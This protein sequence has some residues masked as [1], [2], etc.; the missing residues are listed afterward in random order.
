[1]TDDTVRV[2]PFSDE[3]QPVFERLNLEWIE[4]HFWVEDLDREILSDPRETIIKNGGQVLFALHGDEA[5]GTCALIAAGDG[6]Y[7]LSKMAVDVAA[8]GH[9]FGDVLMHAAIEWARANGA[10]EI[11]LESNTVMEPAI[12]LYEKHGFVTTRLGQGD[13]YER[14]NIRMTLD[15]A[16]C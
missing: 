4:K 11:F 2:V 9:G 14:S 6:V 5:V 12:R 15:L 16:P 3:L 8:R 7:E 13:E 1:M 10:R